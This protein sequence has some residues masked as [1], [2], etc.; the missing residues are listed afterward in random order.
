MPRVIHTLTRSRRKKNWLNGLLRAYWSFYPRQVSRDEEIYELGRTYIPMRNNRMRDIFLRVHSIL[1]TRYSCTYMMIPVQCSRHTG[2]GGCEMVQS[3]EREPKWIGSYKVYT[4]VNNWHEPE[5]VCNMRMEG[6]TEI[7]RREST[8]FL[9]R[10]ELKRTARRSRGR[11]PLFGY[12]GHRLQT[13]PM[14]CFASTSSWIVTR[15]HQW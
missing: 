4:A 7:A 3:T 11:S 1:V 8:G 13:G 15:N 9:Y 14:S 12:E 6:A 10:T 5:K 2:Y